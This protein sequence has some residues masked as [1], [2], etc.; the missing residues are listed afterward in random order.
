MLYSANYPK[1]FSKAW[2]TEAGGGE[3]QNPPSP[4][5]PSLRIFC[6]TTSKIV[7]LTFQLHPHVET[8]LEATVGAALPL[9]LVDNTAAVRHAGVHLLVLDGA[10]EEALAGLAGEEAVVVAGHLGGGGE[11]IFVDTLFFF[12]L[13]PSEN[14]PFL[15]LFLRQSRQ[16]VKK[17]SHLSTI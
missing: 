11:N 5:P 10:L 12:F 3:G 7:Q 14:A 8:L 4:F 9:G 13:P 2:V 16:E 17:T 1:K 15:F 6:K